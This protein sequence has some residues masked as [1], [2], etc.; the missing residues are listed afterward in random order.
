[1]PVW[2]LDELQV[3]AAHIRANSNDEFLMSALASEKIKE[4]YSRFGG[5]FRYVIPLTGEA[6]IAVQRNQD[7]ILEQAS[8]AFSDYISNGRGRGKSGLAF[9]AWAI[10]LPR[11]HLRTQS[12]RRTR[13]TGHICNKYSD[14][15]NYYTIAEKT[16]ENT[17]YTET[18]T[19]GHICNMYSDSNIII[20]ERTFENT[21]HGELENKEYCTPPTQHSSVHTRYS[22]TCAYAVSVSI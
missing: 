18:R 21:V 10:D 3:V 7:S 4:R 14:S 16:F 2:Q 15:N 17:E 19:T 22:H 5:I 8:L 11:E 20:A 9:I 13:N 1:M 12:T 6:L